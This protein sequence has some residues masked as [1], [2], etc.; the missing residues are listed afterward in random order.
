MLNT[1]NSESKVLVTTR[2]KGLLANSEQVE[3]GLPS[4]AES[5]K[6]LLAA[7]GL[8]H[9]VEDVPAEA[10]EVVELCGNLRPSSPAIP[11]RYSRKL[12]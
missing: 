5:V 4:T 9:L 7:A 1:V 8:E 2:I 11:T 6:L 12:H 10:L 3:V